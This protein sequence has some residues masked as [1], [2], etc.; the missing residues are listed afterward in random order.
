M[1]SI[2]IRINSKEATQ[3]E[4]MGYTS[5]EGIYDKRI[6]AEQGSV[7][8]RRGIRKRLLQGTA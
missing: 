2:A 7:E 4:K 1:I 5:I 3:C 6:C 8:K